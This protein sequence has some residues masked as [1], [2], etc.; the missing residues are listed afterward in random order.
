MNTLFLFGHI[1]LTPGQVEAVYNLG[2]ELNLPVRM[3]NLIF[4]LNR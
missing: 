3:R 2:F 1:H 4:N